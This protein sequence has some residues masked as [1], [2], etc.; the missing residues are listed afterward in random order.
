MK[1]LESKI[2][3]SMHIMDFKMDISKSKSGSDRPELEFL[4]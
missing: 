4:V 2:K 1:Q 3:S